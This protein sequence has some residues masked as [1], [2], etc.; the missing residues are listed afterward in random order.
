MESNSVFNHSSARE[1]DVFNHEYD[2]TGRHKVLLT[3]PGDVL[4]FFFRD[5]FSLMTTQKMT[6][7]EGNGTKKQRCMTSNKRLIS[8]KE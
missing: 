2:R 5:I 6:L 1:P 3:P 7:I 4:S 8:P